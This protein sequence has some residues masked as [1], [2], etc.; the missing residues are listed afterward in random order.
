MT[1]W[2]NDQLGIGRLMG[3]VT[4]HLPSDGWVRVKKPIDHDHA[5]TPDRMRFSATE[6][7][8]CS[9]GVLL[10]HSSGGW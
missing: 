2:K 5:P 9:S 4:H 3:E 6:N 1:Q 10:M 8:R 7:T